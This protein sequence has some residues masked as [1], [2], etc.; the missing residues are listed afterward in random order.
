MAVEDLVMAEE[1][2]SGREEVE[3]NLTLKQELNSI[4]MSYT[5]I[6]SVLP[7]GKDTVLYKMV[8]KRDLDELVRINR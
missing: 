2:I 5:G 6:Q 8:L 3:W 4:E 1:A 7:V